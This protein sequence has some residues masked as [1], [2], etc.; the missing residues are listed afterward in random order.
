MDNREKKDLH[1]IVTESLF[2][3]DEKIKIKNICAVSA[4]II[5][6]IKNDEYEWE[7]N[8]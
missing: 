2:G 1:K 8:I 6:K 4:K 5:I 3:I 7:M